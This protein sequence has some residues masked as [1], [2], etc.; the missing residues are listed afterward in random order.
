VEGII[1]VTVATPLNFSPFFAN[2]AEIQT[3]H[4]INVHLFS[5]QNGQNYNL[6]QKR[7][8]QDP[9]LLEQHIDKYHILV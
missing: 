5:D 9:Y 1:T 8:A 4:P 7:M 3:S 2:M 6:P